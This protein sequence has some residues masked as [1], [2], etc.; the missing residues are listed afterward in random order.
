MNSSRPLTE[1]ELKKFGLVTALIFVILFGLFLPWVFDHSLPL[2]PWVMAALLST[3]ALLSPSRLR[4][5]HHYWMLLGAKLGWINNRIIL[6]S[7]FFVLFTPLGIIM[8]LFGYDPLSTKRKPIN[9][10]GTDETSYRV[11]RDD[12][13]LTERM[14]N[15]Y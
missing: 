12:E 9:K 11:I 7:I 13:R 10:A 2:W 3:T 4:K 14:E 1:L 5:V 15:P 8:R 6:G